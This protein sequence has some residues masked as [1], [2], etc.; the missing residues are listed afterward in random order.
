MFSPGFCD[1][2]V[3]V[4]LDFESGKLLDEAGVKDLVIR[5]FQLGYRTLA[6]NVQIHQDELT[7]KKV[8][9]CSALL[10]PQNKAKPRSTPIVF[11]AN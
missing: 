8:K 4:S 6:L 7:T 2:N 9:G 3:P 5:A 1:L 10:D 11:R